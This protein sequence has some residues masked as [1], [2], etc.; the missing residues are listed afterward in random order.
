MRT[1][2][3][4]AR[5]RRLG[6]AA[7]LLLVA[8]CAAGGKRSRQPEAQVVAV[9]RN[10]LTPPVSVT[11]RFV[12]DSGRR[13]GFTS[14]SPNGTARLAVSQPSFVGF[15]RLV[16]EPTGRAT[17]TSSPFTVT[18]GTQIEWSLLTNSMRVFQAEESSRF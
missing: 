18:P 1:R 8:G 17:I 12:S 2:R 10:D 16:A 14:V 13:L 7:I 9:V 15:Y 5:A 3:V 4:Y 6:P 11:V